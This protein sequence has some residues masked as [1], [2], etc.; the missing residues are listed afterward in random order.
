MANLS[1][2]NRV[3][4]EPIME[5]IDPHELSS[6]STLRVLKN[7]SIPSSNQPNVIIVIQTA[8][9]T[10]RSRGRLFRLK[11]SHYIQCQTSN[12]VKSLFLGRE[13]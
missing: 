6:L 2:H 9:L 1:P 3:R 7:R 10:Q 11:A 8:T 5:S 13:A 4:R 12:L